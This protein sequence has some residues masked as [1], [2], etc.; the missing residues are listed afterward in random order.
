MK[1]Y[2]FFI[3][4]LLFILTGCQNKQILVAFDPNGGSFVSPQLIEYGK[5]ITIPEPTKEGYQFGGWYY[6][7]KLTKQYQG[8]W[9]TESEVLYAKWVPET[10]Q[11]S[12]VYP[13]EPIE[14]EYLEKII[15]PTP[16]ENEGLL[17][18]G[19]YWDQELTQL[20]T[21]DYMPLYGATLY[22][23]WTHKTYEV[24]FFDYQGLIDCQIINH[25]DSATPPAE[26]LREG[27]DFIGWDQDYSQITSDLNIYACYQ[28]QNYIV[29]FET[30]GGNDIAPIICEYNTKIE[31][32]EEPK[33]P[34]KV[35]QGWFLDSN[36]TIPYQSTPI[37][38]NTTLYAKWNDAFSYILK[39][40]NTY[41]I[42]K[43]HGND[44]EVIIP[45][46]FLDRKVT[47]VGAN[48]FAGS[49]TIKKIIIS[50]NI[51][52]LND[53]A[54]Y[55]II[56][57]EEIIISD[58]VH[59]IGEGAFSSCP[60]LQKIKLPFIGKSKTAQGTE[61]HFGYIFGTKEY[62]GSYHVRLP[63]NNEEINYF[64]IP[65]SLQKIELTTLSELQD[66]AFYNCHYIK[67]I[68]LPE[69]LNQIGDNAFYQCFALETINFPRELIQIGD[70]SFYDCISLQEI[71]FNNK[72]EKI[73][74]YAFKGCI[75]LQNVAFNNARI[76]NLGVGTFLSCSAIEVISLPDTITEIPAGLFAYCS[77][78]KEIKFPEQ[79]NKI[80]K[81][82][83]DHCFNLRYFLSPDYIELIDDYAFANCLNLDS[84]Y[85]KKKLG[86]LGKDVFS[87]CDKLVTL[88]Y[89]G[90]NE[91]WEL[92]IRETNSK[93]E[94]ITIIYNY[95]F[96]I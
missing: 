61:S 64:F 90:N 31:K 54:F 10:Y 15:L 50:D 43:Y 94:S 85:I 2:C 21:L 18:A 81:Y 14:G 11:I 69:N 80:G 12:F 76:L 91:E 4:L 3:I 28:P 75:K 29:T 87:Q 25:N 27:Y 58:N 22:P 65:Q 77:L 86:F 34:L 55:D 35:F 73:G 44:E 79:I 72:L 52:Y 78:L 53:Y 47:S 20:F 82:A 24:K 84:V 67:E 36:Y 30:F 38:E 9:F 6:D 46:T 17:F 42:Y 59:S 71:S 13:L 89:E 63:L 23:K 83:F 16:S 40:N 26:P 92:I 74:N 56:N 57:L 41:E 32:L 8:E 45:E 49:E 68:V 70:N 88:Y 60:N 66:N 48:A 62:L 93:L 39:Y 19:W 7:A 33:K 96:P 37:K 51:E 5:P 95:S 1:K